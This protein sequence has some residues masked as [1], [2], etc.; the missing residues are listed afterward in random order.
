[1]RA[2]LLDLSGATAVDELLQD[3][4]LAARGL[5][6]RPGFAAVAA[7]TIALGVGA[8]TAVF[9]AADAA[10]L[11]PLPYAAPE[12][13]MHVSLTVPARGVEPPRDDVP[14]SYPKFAAFR[15]AQAVFSD[16]TLW[17]GRDLTV[18][19]PAG[20]ERVPGELTDAGYLPALGVRPALGRNFAADESRRP[21]GPRVAL[22]GD[23]FWR[24]RL[25]A[26]PGAVGRAITVGGEPFTVVG[27]L[28]PGFRGLSGRA[29]LWV[30][31]L[32]RP[33]AE[34]AEADVHSYALVARLRPDVAA[35]RARAA[36]RAL[37][38]RVDALHPNRDVPG[39]RWGADARPLDSTR[40]APAVRRS[41]AVLLGA[42]G[43]VLA[44][45]CA[46]VATLLLLRGA[47]RRR[48]LAVRAALGAGRRRLV[49]QLL[50]ETALLVGVGGTAGVALAWAGVRALRALDPARV[51]AGGAGEAT[52]LAAGA[53]RLDGR[54]LLVA[55]GLT[56]LAAL[57]AGLVPA[58]DAARLAL[59]DALHDGRA[60]ARRRG[61]DLLVGAEVAI[62]LVLLAGTGLLLRS[63]DNLLAVRPGFDAAGVLAARVGLPEAPG[64]RG[65]DAAAFYGRVLE[66]VAGRAGGGR[67]RARR[68]RALR[69]Q[70]QHRPR[71]A[72]RP[73]AAAAR[74]RAAR[75]R[76]LGDA[77]VGPRARRAAPARPRPH[78]GRRAW[79]AQGGARQRER[80]APLLAR[81]ATRSA[82]R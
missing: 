39:E 79:R 6:T 72:A 22:V 17:A 8:G 29:E 46:N 68:L 50:T 69:P 14:W 11:R 37:G 63:L 5:R 26:D 73:R 61:R 4:R 10:L 1:V 55:A 28:P 30:P 76:A 19:G 21:G 66:R 56:A 24:R 43:L 3:V 36:V 75:R 45:G 38:A 78:G 31:L 2:R 49:R 70:L 9:C 58:L 65:V 57:L 16:L 82:G 52:A 81:A 23:A 67:R 53:V 25:G 54:A 62:A 34:L 44:V 47:A 71:P 42:A 33:A 12:R 32:S 35:E 59:R 48:E 7:L 20:S 27:V 51:L 74:R 18:R 77:R 80:R 41:L 15:D 64:A 40:A 60:A 13:L